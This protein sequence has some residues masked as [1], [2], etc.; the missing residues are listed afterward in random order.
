MKPKQTYLW[1]RTGNSL[2]IAN[3]QKAPVLGKSRLHSR[4]IAKICGDWPNNTMNI[5]Q[6]DN[7]TLAGE[8]LYHAIGTRTT[9]LEHS[10]HRPV[11]TP[12]GIYTPGTDHRK[13]NLS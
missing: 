4:C 5:F 1:H 10:G 3:E 13:H 9:Q 7:K 12:G 8:P 11:Y 2:E 6:H